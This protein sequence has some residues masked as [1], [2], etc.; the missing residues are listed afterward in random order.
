MPLRTPVSIHANESLAARQEL[1]TRYPRRRNSESRGTV[2]PPGIRTQCVD[3]PPVNC[4]HLTHIPLADPT[5]IVFKVNERRRAGQLCLLE[6]QAVHTCASREGEDGCREK[7]RPPPRFGSL[8]PVNSDGVGHRPVT[9]GPPV[10]EERHRNARESGA[11][12]L[13][14]V[15]NLAIRGSCRS[16]VCRDRHVTAVARRATGCRSVRSPGASAE[17][18]VVTR[19]RRDE[20][21]AD[22]ETSL[23]KVPP[24]LRRK[25]VAGAYHAQP[26]EAKHAFESGSSPPPRSDRA[27]HGRRQPSLAACCWERWPPRF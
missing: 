8:G 23:C 10:C 25:T 26:G 3:T 15:R 16:V 5:K 6:R 2:G 7:T 22:P 11:S 18:A 1:R 19:K 27:V 20:T 13:R 14:A 12:H 21:R 17:L 24:M 9:P 4:A